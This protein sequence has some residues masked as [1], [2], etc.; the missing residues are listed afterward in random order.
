[1]Y[2]A[3]EVSHGKSPD[4]RGGN[5]YD[6]DLNLTLSPRSSKHGQDYVSE[7]LEVEQETEAALTN[8]Y[9]KGFTAYFKQRAKADTVQSQARDEP[10]VQAQAQLSLIK[11]KKR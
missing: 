5:Q 4:D 10:Q 8:V 1:M 2:A 6:Y 7:L 3:A 11:A 9:N